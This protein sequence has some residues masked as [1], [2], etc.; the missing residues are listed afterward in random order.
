MTTVAL[1][2]EPPHPDALPGLAD[3]LSPAGREQLAAAFLRDLARAATAAAGDTVLVVRDGPA[4]GHDEAAAQARVRETLA[5]LEDVDAAGLRVE[6]AV[7]STPSARLGNTATHLLERE[8]AISVLAVWPG[9]PLVDRSTVDGAAMRLRQHEV[10][11]G[12]ATGGGVAL[13]GFG[14]PVDFTDA[15]ATPAL[16]TL[17]DRAVDAGLSVDYV[18]DRVRV[19]G[20]D[21]LAE[22]LVR[23]RAR[24]RAGRAV[25]AATT[26]AVADLGLRVEATDSGLRPVAD[27]P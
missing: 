23:L 16:T 20:P 18:D 22:L 2:V 7:G 13:A 3:V 14:E 26:A 15:L 24:E 5:A 6:R 10:V 9:A 19:G 4:V 17:T 25:P 21:A 1:L 8:D 27:D 11:L 12:P